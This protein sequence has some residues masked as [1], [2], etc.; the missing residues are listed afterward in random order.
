MNKYEVLESLTQM[1][2]VLI[3][4]RDEQTAIKCSDK[5]DICN[6]FDRI[7]DSIEELKERFKEEGVE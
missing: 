1:Q 5:H 2:V 7:R 3:E 4:L 6:D